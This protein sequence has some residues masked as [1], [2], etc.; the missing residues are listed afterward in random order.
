MKRRD[1]QTNEVR[2]PEVA[3]INIKFQSEHGLPGF[4]FFIEA[5]GEEIWSGMDLQTHYPEILKQYPD[6]ELLINWR[7]FPVTWV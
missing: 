6:K 7:S 1:M 5:D 3:L 2:A 4:E